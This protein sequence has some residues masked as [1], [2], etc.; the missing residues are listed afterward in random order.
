M[1]S[2][3][4]VT[5]IVSSLPE[6][7]EGTSYGNRAWAVAGKT[8][9]WVRPFSQADIKRYGNKTPP[10]GP[11][12]GVRTADLDEKDAV[13]SAGVTGVFTI[14]HFDGFAGLL[15]QLDVVDDDTLNGLIED[16]WMARAPL[17]VIDDYVDT[18]PPAD[19]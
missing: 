3:E 13:L 18:E 7:T 17:H 15:I 9:V 16:A 11:I 12:L 4:D 2:L 1:A 5:T 10:T 14:P 19:I 8:F 6:V